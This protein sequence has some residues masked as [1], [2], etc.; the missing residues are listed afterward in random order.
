MNNTG[1]ILIL[2]YPETIVKISSEWYLSYLR[3]FGIGRKNY[4]RAGHAAL[5]LIEKTTGILEYYDF[6]RYITPKH[7][8]RVRSVET[9]HELEMPLIAEMDQGELKNLNDILKFLATNPKLTHG[10]GKMIASVCDVV[11]YKKA[12]SYILMMQERDF[13][14]YAVF[15][16]DASNCSR[17][18]T[19]TLI[20]GVTDTRIRNRLLRSLRFTPST[21]GNV[22]IGNSKQ[23]VYE[24]S[25]Q[26]EINKFS[27]TVRRENIKYFLD[28]LSVFKPD[29]I[30]NLHPKPVDGLSSHAQ[31]LSGTGSGAWFEKHRCKWHVSGSGR[32]LQ[33]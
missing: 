4:V 3:Y 21:L 12:K 29:H 5:V 17:F 1:I 13:V 15:K 8:G 16:G 9:D 27:S 32:F 31:W 33:L 6:G 28:K 22:V 26:G 10:E 23:I 18:V 2:A 24:V 30:G 19:D 7:H 14:P 11:D 25:D 20:E